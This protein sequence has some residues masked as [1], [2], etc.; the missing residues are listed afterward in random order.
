[1]PDVA[2]V[3][4]PAAVTFGH[5]EVVVFFFALG[6]LLMTARVLG[7]MARRYNQ[8][9]VLGELLA[10]VV[11]GPTLFGA[12]APQASTWLFPTEGAFPIALKAITTV[13]IALFLLVA[14]LEVDLTIV[15]RQGRSCA[16][17]SLLGVLVPFGVGFAAGTIAPEFLGSANE[18]PL[19]FALFLGTALAISALP[20]IARTLMD[21]GIYKSDFGMVVI[22]AAVVDDIMGW[23]LF[24]VLLSLIGGGANHP[25]G[26]GT[27]VVL[28]VVFAAAMMTVGRWLV[29]RALPFVQAYSEWPGGVLAV[30]A[31]MTF[32]IGGFTEWLGVH[33]IFGAF[34]FGIALGDSPHM[35]EKTRTIIEQ[36]VG[37]IFA[38]LFFASLGLK[39][40]FAAN[41][42]PL[43]VGVIVAIAC[44]SKLV[45]CTLGAR[46]ASY[47]FRDALAV[48]FAMNAR[49]AMGTVLAL[50]ALE[51]GLIDERAFVALVVMALVTS[52]M[53]G[54][55]IQK[56]L[57][58][59]RAVRFV[60]YLPARG[61]LAGMKATTRDE[62]IRELS[63]IAANAAKLPAD[64]VVEKVM[65]RE[66]SMS[67][68]I[69]NGVAVPHA[70]LEGI[71]TPVVVVG[72]S[73][74]G[75]EFDSP[76][77]LPVRV[78]FLI[79]TERD[80]VK[81]QVGILADIARRFRRPAMA[82]LASSKPDRIQFLALINSE[83]D[84]TAHL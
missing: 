56:L 2:P 33:A 75:V 3:A 27:T 23:M 5:S 74:D 66:V 51:A 42:D 57:T 15:R 12:I 60:D 81:D 25:F 77:G 68:A 14:G 50:L 10:G 71:K 59:E 36:F 73:R 65:E 70:R 21:I 11:L 55:A 32:L 69:G 46:L 18:Y 38:P 79:L 61:V 28:V 58:R 13:G 40:N 78:V 1:M 17:I 39:V 62:A 6:V 24:A 72:L 30:A 34:L 44:A 49:G 7:E 48:G 67:T 43:L 84:A 53:A 52:M 26:V 16:I 76:D 63:A 82:E 9:A 47:P 64:I 35:R 4:T 19:A 37:S 80:G 31:A 29:N 54:P 8:P 41:F 22:G 45:G 20:V 83:A